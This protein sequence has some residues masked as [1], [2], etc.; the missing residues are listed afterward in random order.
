[1]KELPPPLR[2]AA[3]T[4]PNEASAAD[5]LAKVH[6]HGDA[7]P[8]PGSAERAWRGVEAGVAPAK[9][10]WLK[11]VLVIVLTG[12]AMFFGWW[13]LR[14]DDPPLPPLPPLPPASAPVT[15]VEPPA[16]QPV[17]EKIVA[18]KIAPSPTP[19]PTLVEALAQV[20]AG[21]LDKAEKLYRTIADLDPAK[22]EVAMLALAKMR[23]TKQQRVSEGLKMLDAQDV[24]FKTGTLRQERALSRIDAL[25]RTQACDEAKAA[26]KAY[27]AEFTHAL[28][29]L[30][31]IDASQCVA[32]R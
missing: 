20:Q 25:F 9:L 15:S 4:D 1:M 10:V 31:N 12:A 26:V 8:P 28:D 7:A 23:I 13:W 32:P 5:A 14:G 3:P 21:K 18:P 24:R 30:K 6:A 16:S 27:A 2:N 11:I 19:V 29:S 17:P 22:A